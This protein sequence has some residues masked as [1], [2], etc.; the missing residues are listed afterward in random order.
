M[1]RNADPPLARKP[2][3]G[4][5]RP[6]FWR[7]PIRGPWLTAILGSVLLVGIT[8]L[9][10]TGLLSYA[11]YNP[12]LHG[13]D[14]TSHKGVLGFYLF[15]WPTRPYWLYRV[16]QGVHVILGLALLP[17]LLGKLWS[18]IPKLFDWPPV[19]S[20]AQLLERLSLLFLVGG[21]LFE[22]VTGILDIQYYYVFPGSFYKL[23]FYGAWVF[24]AAFVVHV[25]LKLPRMV[26]ALRSRSLRRELRT[27]TAHTVPEQPD[28]DRLVT[29]NPAQPSMSRRGA[30]GLIGAGSLTLVALSVG[31]SVG[32]SLRRTAVLAPRGQDLGSG[33]NDFQVNKTAADRGVQADK[34]GSSWRLELRGGSSDRDLSR[35]ELLT[36]PQH[37]AGLPIAC[38]EGWSTE[39]Q[40]WSGVRLADLAQLAGVP[41]PRSVYV[42]SIEPAGAFRSATLRRNQVLDGDAL[43]ALM[44]NGTQLSADHGYPARVIVPDAP[45]VH[46]TKWVA[47]MTFEA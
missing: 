40:Q 10:V 46:N 13:N 19:R 31:Q 2:P 45:G 47:R 35:D 42:E 16:N 18:V 7:S 8:V 32:G 39:N 6:A 17:V 12:D 37:T 33:P 25:V 34:T 5:A 21:A 44:V 4:P 29:P 28:P 9:F 22:F 11:S 38:V 30:L 24:I 14:F 41:R 15:A 26:T 23:H 27:D 3:P 1:V 43:L 20:P 36:M